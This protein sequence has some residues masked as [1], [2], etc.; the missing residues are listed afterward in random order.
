MGTQR[1]AGPIEE[2][3]VVG[4]SDWQQERGAFG[5]WVS[6]AP[7]KYW[8]TLHV[9]AE[10]ALPVTNKRGEP[11]ADL[12]AAGAV[13]THLIAPPTVG[14]LTIRNGFIQY[15]PGTGSAVHWN[16]AEEAYYVIEGSGYIE[17]E[18]ERHDF[19]A[20]DGVFVPLRA[21]HRV[22]NDSDV[23]LRMV[24]IASIPLRPCDDLAAPSIDYREYME[25]V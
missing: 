9:A 5:D 22:V 14:A 11:V 23:P 6:E 25:E 21:R 18:G 2:Q 13:A 16:N 17:V 10:D 24:V 7:A 12:A 3:H 1:P 19:E 4:R 15:P 8:K 20:G